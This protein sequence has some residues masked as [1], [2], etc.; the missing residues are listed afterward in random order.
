VNLWLFT[1]AVSTIQFRVECGRMIMNGEQI[2]REET[3]MI[4]LKILTGHS[5]RKAE[6]NHENHESE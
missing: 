5:P 2:I 1:D 4:Y 3:V 6:E